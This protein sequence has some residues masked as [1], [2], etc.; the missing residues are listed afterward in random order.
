MAIKIRKDGVVQDLVINANEVRVLDKDGNFRSKN[1]E[2]VLKELNMNGGSGGGTG[3]GGSGYPKDA[4]Y[5]YVKDSE[6][7]MDGVWFDESDVISDDSNIQDNSIVKSIREYIDTDVKKIVNQNKVLVE[8]NAEVVND[9]QSKVGERLDVV[10]QLSNPN[11]LING[12]FQIQEHNY[13]EKTFTNQTKYV[14]NR[15][16]LAS[17]HDIPVYT[18]MR[19]RDFQLVFT[20]QGNT[21]SN[22]RYYFEVEDVKKWVGKTLTYSL[23][24]KSE[25]SGSDNWKNYGVDVFSSPSNAVNVT[26][27]Q[28]KHFTL[29]DGYT[30]KEVTF[31]VNSVDDGLTKFH[32]QFL[33]GSGNGTL[34]G[35]HHVRF[36]KLEYGNT[37]TPFVPRPYGE[38][39]ALCQRYYQKYYRHSTYNLS[40]WLS[41]RLA[42]HRDGDNITFMFDIPEMRTAPT[43]NII[44]NPLAIR[45]QGSGGNITNDVTITPY[46]PFT[47]GFNLR[48]EADAG[49]FDT[50]RLYRCETY[51]SGDGVS[52]N[53]VECN[54]EIL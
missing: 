42:D 8:S 14:V 54:A 28:H 35:Y 6:P 23:E 20:A 45:V 46:N 44:G 9:I 50:N 38:E 22:L 43:V 34:F 19:D 13:L 4:E 53:Y 16:V 17:E 21:N 15:W 47:N 40:K 3:T 5:V 1:L 26:V 39:L 32:I 2:T 51:N 29:D 49:V 36:V 18:R 48:V 24:Y 31:K 37:A 33:R 7:D 10:P 30:R 25:Y 52:H 27:L 11:L 12:D 41:G